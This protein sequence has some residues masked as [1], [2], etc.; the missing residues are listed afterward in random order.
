MSWPA[1]LNGDNVHYGTPINATA[2][3]AACREGLPVA[4]RPPLRQASRTSVSAPTPG[5]PR[6]LPASY[7]G[8]WGIRTTHGRLPLTHMV[9]LHPSFD[10]ATWFARDAS[11][12][13]ACR[14]CAAGPDRFAR[15]ES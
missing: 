5:A 6:A 7:C 11:G 2:R 1:S 10:T 14:T 9:P 13:C 8:I 3:A 4:L 15:G 12:L